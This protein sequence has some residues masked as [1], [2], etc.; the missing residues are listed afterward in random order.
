MAKYSITW[1]KIAL[2]QRREVFEYWNNRTR[3][4]KYSIKL[5]YAINARINILI[6]NPIAFKDINLLEIRE[7]AMDHFSIYYKV[8]NNK[9]SIISFWDNRQDPDKLLEIIKLKK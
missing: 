5:L 8:D 9:I 2:K 3:N 1:T 7:I 6:E 4:N